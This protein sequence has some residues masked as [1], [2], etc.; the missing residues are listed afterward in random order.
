MTRSQ[1]RKFVLFMK[2]Y[3]A[4]SIGLMLAV[5]AHHLLTNA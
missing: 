1:H 4:A 5:L 2:V 3:L